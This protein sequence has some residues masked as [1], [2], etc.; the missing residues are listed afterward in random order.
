M[1]ILANLR[2]T[3]SKGINIYR[4][5]VGVCFIIAPSIFDHISMGISIIFVAAGLQRLTSIWLIKR[6]RLFYII[7]G[8]Y[9]AA[10]VTGAI[11][12]FI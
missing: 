6:A 10:M 7:N 2:E 8:I 9:V 4:L 1:K 12:I 11:L 3:F 5:V